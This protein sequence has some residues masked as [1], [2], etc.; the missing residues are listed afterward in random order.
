MNLDVRIFHA[1]NDFARNTPWL[2]PL[3]AAYANDGVLLFVALLLGGWWLARSS[4]NPMAMTS[5]LWTPLGVFAALLVYDPIAVSVNETRPCN[6]LRDIVVLHCNTDG[7]FPSIHA[8]IAAAVAAGL[9]LTNRY[10]GVVAAVAAVVMAFARVYVGAHYPSDVVAG[11]VLGVVVS[12]A[13]YFL[14]RPLLRRLLDVIER[15]RLRGL[16]TATPRDRRIP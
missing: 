12:W 14:F 6:A 5:V 8:V 1:I 7:G 16:V 2:H 3:M 11:L 4:E 10:L 9:W 13:G 15:T